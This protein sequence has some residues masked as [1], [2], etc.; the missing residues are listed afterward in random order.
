MS[1]FCHCF[2]G[3]TSVGLVECRPE[4]EK[5]LPRPVFFFFPSKC[6]SAHASAVKAC[7]SLAAGYLSV[8]HNKVAIVHLLPKSLQVQEPAKLV[9]WIFWQPL[10][11][12]V[13]FRAWSQGQWTCM[14]S[15]RRSSKV[16][17]KLELSCWSAWLHS[18]ASLVTN[19]ALS[20]R[21]I[22]VQF[23]HF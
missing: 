1:S 15:Y 5:S 9:T 11:F 18:D 12:C 16:F 10:L 7:L 6:L 14:V 22:I 23:F 2:F 19:Q 8:S 13:F 20:Q 3:I 17:E 21:R 4:N